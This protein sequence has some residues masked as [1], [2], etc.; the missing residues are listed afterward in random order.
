MVP[1]TFGKSQ[2]LVFL[3]KNGSLFEDSINDPNATEYLPKEGGVVSLF[4]HS[5]EVAWWV[6]LKRLPKDIDCSLLD[7]DS[8]GY[9]DCLVVGDNNLLKAIQPLSGNIS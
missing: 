9:K 1:S 4:G 6:K 5:G 7:V 2:N 8:D 3:F